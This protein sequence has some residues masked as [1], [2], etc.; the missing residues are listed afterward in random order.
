MGQVSLIVFTDLDGTLLDRATYSYEPARPALD[1]LAEAGVP[2]VL[3]TSKT[4]AETERWRLVLGNAHPF[5]V[6][7][8]GAAFAPRGYFP[9]ALPAAAARGDYSAIEFGDPY[10]S[11]VASLDA[12][13][14]A[15]GVRVR[16]FHHMSPEEIARTA[17]LSIEEARLAAAREYDEPFEVLDPA[18][19]TAL[20][21]EIR[22]RGRRWTQGGRFYHITGNN[23]KAGAVLALRDAYRRMHADLVT[24]GLG[25]GLNDAEFLRAVDIAYLVRS[26]HSAELRARVPSGRLTAGAGPEGWNQAILEVVPE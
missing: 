22:R 5:I 4:R 13:S 26:P 21:E 24:V 7:N 6:E 10:D 23:D 15:T 17:G 9:F 14:L 3:C 11:L 12:A 19:A 20:L 16:G 1:A 2:V 25:D 18:G 8:G